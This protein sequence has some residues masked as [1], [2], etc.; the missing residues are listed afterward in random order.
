MREWSWVRGGSTSDL[1][2]RNVVGSFHDAAE[3]D[4]DEVDIAWLEDWGCLT[5]SRGLVLQ[6]F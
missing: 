3:K 5:R 6:S 2:R 1:E 4:G